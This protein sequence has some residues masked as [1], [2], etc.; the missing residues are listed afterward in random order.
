MTLEEYTDREALYTRARQ[1]VEWGNNTLV[2][3]MKRLRVILCD[4]DIFNSNV[5]ELSL[6]LHNIRVDFGERNQLKRFFTKLKY[7]AEEEDYNVGFDEVE[8]DSD[9][10][11]DDGDEEVNA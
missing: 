3:F 11:Y 1:P 4:D 8:E 7:K 6:L 5:M 9:A 2:Q 10:E